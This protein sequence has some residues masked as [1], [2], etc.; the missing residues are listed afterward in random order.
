[1]IFDV[2]LFQWHLFKNLEQKLKDK[3]VSV[4]FRAAPSI[5]PSSD[6]FTSISTKFETYVKFV[7]S[8]YRVDV[9]GQVFYFFF[10]N[11]KNLTDNS[12]TWPS[13]VEVI[14]SDRSNTTTLFKYHYFGNK[15]DGVLTHQMSAEY[16]DVD[17]MKKD[18]KTL[19]DF[20]VDEFLK[21]V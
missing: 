8:T 7:Q 1:M 21:R 10:R 20:I 11:A 16:N 17:D 3:Y 13:S 4:S 14:K 18:I 15:P 2:T 19:S 6:M 5:R 9:D 12:F